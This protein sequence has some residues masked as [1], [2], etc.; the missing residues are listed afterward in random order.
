MTGQLTKVLELA[1]TQLAK[2][3]TQL[4]KVLEL[5][6]TQLAAGT[7]KAFHPRSLVG[8]GDVS[9]HTMASPA[10]AGAPD[11]PTL[12]PPTLDPPTL[13]PPTLDPPAL[14]P[15]GAGGC[16][17]GCH[18]CHPPRTSSSHSELENGDEEGRGAYSDSEAAEWP[19]PLLGNVF[20]LRSPILSRQ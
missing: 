10:P 15:P 14:D 3:T 16:H 9:A 13:D 8:L 6:T 1:T 17:G 18:I 12:D 2:V 4:P 7:R 5:A 20:S 11:P 19:T